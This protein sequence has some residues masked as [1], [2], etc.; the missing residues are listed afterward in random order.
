MQFALTDNLT[1]DGA[2]G[3]TKYKIHDVIA[4]GGPNLFP[5]QAS[6]T[7]NLGATYTLHNTSVGNFTANVNY[8]YTAKQQTYPESTDPAWKSDGAYEL[9]GYSVVNGRVQWTST[10]RRNVVTLF[11]NNLLDRD[12]ADLRHEVRW[13]LLGYLQPRS[14]LV[15]HARS[16]QRRRPAAQHGQ[17]DARSPARVRHHAAAQLQLSLLQGSPAATPR[18]LRRAVLAPAQY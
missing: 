12:Y 14:G 5:P 10:D 8:A 18:T 6:P 4:N 13:R 16:D 7:A 9:P 11:V 2:L 1:L 15:R 3:T 17:R